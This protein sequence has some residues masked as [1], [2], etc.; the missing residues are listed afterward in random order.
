MNCSKNTLMRVFHLHSIVNDGHTVHL[1]LRTVGALLL[2]DTITGRIWSIR[3]LST[4]IQAA[5]IHNSIWILFCTSRNPGHSK[6]MNLQRLIPKPH[7]SEIQLLSH[8]HIRSCKPSVGNYCNWSDCNFQLPLVIW[9]VCSLD[10]T[11]S[12]SQWVS[13]L[14]TARRQLL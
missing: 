11:V 3:P 5:V 6:K 13:L 2:Q 1:I 7:R 8:K 14:F 4:K 10:K 12:H 9:F